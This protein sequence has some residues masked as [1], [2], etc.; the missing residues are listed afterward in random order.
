MNE[1]CS[2]PNKTCKIS[3]DVQC[4][5]KPK[6]T[7]ETPHSDLTNVATN[8]VNV[9]CN[10]K[11]TKVST[12][13]GVAGAAKNRHCESGVAIKLTKAT[14]GSTVS[15]RNSCMKR[16]HQDKVKRKKKKHKSH[17][18]VA[19]KLPEAPEEISAN[20]KNLLKV[21]TLTFHTNKLN[22]HIC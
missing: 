21:S 16:T 20:W 14:G 22:I 7:S 9:K 12:V 6:S 18:P 11:D 8:C 4:S 2:R 13:A 19:V 15:R 3:T 1:H 10:K 17:K 5:S